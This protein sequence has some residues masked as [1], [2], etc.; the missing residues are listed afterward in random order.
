MV[1]SNQWE[2]VAGKG[3][4]AKSANNNK[5]KESSGK[6]S[7]NGGAPLPTLRVEELGN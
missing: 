2:V 4:K 1:D 5:K 7:S 3:G 6:S